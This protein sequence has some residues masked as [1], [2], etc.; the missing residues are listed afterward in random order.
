MTEVIP[1]NEYPPK[2]EGIRRVYAYAMNAGD[3][4]YFTGFYAEKAFDAWLKEEKAKA[5]D[6][7]RE[8]EAEAQFQD[9]GY[10]DVQHPEN[11]YRE[12]T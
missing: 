9:A 3:L 12:D 7:G 10:G 8:A 4:D 6:E 5:W 11:P 2:T 1:E